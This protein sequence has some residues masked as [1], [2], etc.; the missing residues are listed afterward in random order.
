MPPEPF[1]ANIGGVHVIL[2]EFFE[3]NPKAALGFSGGVDSA[4]LLYAAKKYGADIQPY[5]VK[6]AFQPK[7]EYADVMNL[8][9]ML[10]IGIR[11]I[12]YDILLDTVITSNPKN[13]C[14][15]CKR[16]MF[17]A[18]K[19]QAHN[20]GYDLIIDGT[21]A[22]DDLSDRPGTK[23]MQELSVRS[24]LR[25]CGLTKDKIRELSKEAGLFTWNKPSYSCLATRIH[26]G[27]AITQNL[28]NRIEQSENSLMSMGFSDFRVRVNNGEARLQIKEN[29][30]E[31][32]LNN[33]KEILR[34][35]KPYFKTILLDMKTR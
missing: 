4:Y 19:H 26:T 11:T 5:Y 35:I 2:K 29:Q 6:T 1:F 7:F 34:Q 8:C 18:L 33:R 21:N 25:E 13:R 14:Y 20:D 22:S 15:Y 9:D 30:F 17:T 24:P 23:A 10:D 3:Q 28:L 16:I 27:Q 32:L 31:L 12:E